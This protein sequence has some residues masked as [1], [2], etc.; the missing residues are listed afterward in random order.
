MAN[1]DTT[2]IQTWVDKQDVDQLVS[3][4]IEASNELNYMSLPD[5]PD[6]EHAKEHILSTFFND[7]VST[8]CIAVKDKEELVGVASAVVCPNPLEFSWLAVTNLV[9]LKPDYRNKGRLGYQLLKTYLDV[10]KE[11]GCKAVSFAYIKDKSPRAVKKFLKHFGFTHAEETY[12]K[13]F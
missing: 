7:S 6:R 2:T 13:E 10:C 11:I 1:K 4:L 8:V 5:G 3:L 12:Y 9:Y